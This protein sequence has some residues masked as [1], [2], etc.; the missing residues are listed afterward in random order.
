MKDPKVMRAHE[1]NRELDQ[2]E[3]QSAKLTDKLIAAGFGSKTGQELL[4]MADSLAVSYQT[5]TYRRRD[6]R[7]EIERRYGPNPPRR[8]PRGFGPV[9]AR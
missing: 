9:E 5:L 3:R 4:E 7:H 2:L 8:L 6:L 1:I